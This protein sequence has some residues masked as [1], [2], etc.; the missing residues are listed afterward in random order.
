ME[1]PRKEAP[2]L[3]PDD[4]LQF[5]IVD[6]YIPEADRQ[7]EK[8]EE[9]D[10]YTMMIYGATQDG[11]TVCVNITG[12]EPYFYVKPPETWEQYSDYVFA[13]K[14]ANMRTEMEEEYY[15]CTFR[16]DGRESKYNK[17]IIPKGYEDHFKDMSVVKKKEF[18]GFTNNADF[19]YIK[20]T[21]KSL[22]LYNSLKYYFQSLKPKGFIM[23]ES[24]IDPFLR[25][26]HRQNI[27]PCG[28]VSIK[29][30]EINDD[31]DTRCDYNIETSHE[32]IIPIEVNNIAPLLIASFD[33]ECTSSHGDFPVAKKDYRKVAQDLA[34]IAKA[35]YDIT[36][37][38][39]LYWLETMY[40]TDAI[41]DDDLKVHR[42]YAKHKVNF[43]NYKERVS[44]ISDEIIEILNK[45]A[46]IADDSDDEDED[47]KKAIKPITLKEQNVLEGK[48]NALLSDILP[49]L[50]GDKIIQ[51][52]T[53]VHRYGSDE[54][55]YKNIITLNSCASIE[56]TD[57]I[58]CQSEKDVLMQWKNLMIS[59]NPD[60][61]TGYNIF[62]F[63][64]EYIWI[65]AQ[66]NSIID[67]FSRGLGRKITRK[68]TLV[69]QELSSSALG[70][71]ILKY[72]DMDGTVVID[73]FKVMQREHKLDS[74]K[75]D[76]VAHIFI[77]DKKD[78][79]K[80]HEIFQKFLGTAEDRC[81]IAKYCVQDCALVNRL[82]HKLKILE[83]NIGMGNVC[84][85]PLNY[86]FKRGQGIKIFSLIAKQCM[87]KGH[88]IPVIRAF[89]AKTE[90]DVDGYEGAVVLEP[91]EGI[92][93]NDP[94][95]V[96][97]YGSLYPSSMIAR[98]LSHDCYVMDPKY[99]VDDP[100]IDYIKVSYDLYEGTGDKK[101]KSGVKE[102][103]FA[104]YKDGRKGIIADILTMLLQ[105]RKNTR[106]KM[107]YQTI[108]TLDNLKY[109][110]VLS[111]K[112]DAYELLDIDTN[113]KVVILKENVKE[114]K[115][116]FN[117]FEQDVFDALQ[118]AYKITANSLYG[119]IGARTSPIYL[120]DIAACT[121]ATG[122]EMIML[123]KNFVE[124]NYQ[125]EVIYGDS[126]MPY[127]PLT[128]KTAHQI[129]VATFETIE[130]Q[131]IPYNEF[132][133]DEVGRYNKEQFLPNDIQVWTHKGWAKVKRII[134]HK[135][136]K[137]IYRVQTSLG[138]VD[139]T[140]DHSL[141]DSNADIIKPS[142][143]VV[144]QELL[145]S[146]PKI[147][148]YNQVSDAQQ[149]YVYGQFVAN[150]FYHKQDT[151]Y[152]VMYTWEIVNNSFEV[153]NKCKTYL[154]SIEKIEFVIIY[155]NRQYVLMPVAGKHL[156]EFVAKYACCYY[157]YEHDS[158]RDKIVPHRI[159]NGTLEVMIAFKKG[160]DD[161][162]HTPKNHIFDA[163]QQITAQSY[164]I[165]L[166][167][168]RYHFKI[169]CKENNIIITMT[170][171]DYECDDKIQNI[172]VLHEQYHGYVYD[173]ETEAGVFHGGVGN[174]ILKNTDSIFCRFP[175]KDA[176]G[177][178]V[179]GKDSLQ[180]AIEVG[181][182][183]E[184]NIVS[185]MPRPQKLNYEKSLYPFILFSKKRYVGNLYETDVNKF[186]Q[187]SMGIVLKRR[188]NAPIVKKIYGGIIDILLNQQDLH[189]SIKFLKD[190]LHD[191]VNGKTPI[192]DLV[193]SKSLRASY[194][195]ASKIPHKVLADRIGERDPGNKPQV[196]DRVP[197]V[198]IKVP[199]A[200]LQG[201]RIESPDYIIENNLTPDYLHYITNQ[202]MNPVLQLYAL[203]L[204][205]LP[206]YNKSHEY[207]TEVEEEL[208][209][210]PIYQDDA[211]RKNR[212][213]N[214][215]LNM[216]KELLFDEYIYM[217]SEPKV[218]RGTKKDTVSNEVR[219]KKQKDVAAPVIEGILMAEIKVVQKKETKVIESVAKIS[220]GKDIIW[221]Q[222]NDK[223]K[224]KSKEII[225]II[226]EMVDVAK[227]NSAKLSI[228]INYKQFASD[229]NK[230]LMCY[231]ELEK[232]TMVDDNVIETAM[233]Q[234]DLGTMNN[235]R[236]IIPYEAI[237]GLRN[238]FE[239]R[240]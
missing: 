83:N 208:K 135:T 227:Q 207:W 85:V 110:G 153:L 161:S 74:Y 132:K 94:I 234:N 130:A 224:D 107:E 5:Q 101:R 195:D 18:W 118:L 99:Q 76:N 46:D 179:Y 201:D 136:L 15:K 205:E 84:L 141:L 91:K 170:H 29:E 175:L 225:A 86:L 143:C 41:I 98:N 197:F 193:I 33:I 198:Y 183:V 229:Y 230:S 157:E 32:N 176:N 92:Y 188:D 77:G 104:Q 81:I 152:G 126:V 206:N 173:I 71:N 127:T 31:I 148:Y 146:K 129:Y 64:M 59:L 22:A 121:T 43:S 217:L 116:T 194:K 218:K 156:H 65:R 164:I 184:K 166:Q 186:K 3:N 4:E 1:I 38:F 213:D 108:I 47:E 181:K 123:A 58:A 24:N 66:E 6:W 133:A 144:G 151:E 226:L 28:W 89:D 199:D 55:I 219:T 214:L 82:L 240:I 150:G 62:G 180:Y 56:N 14:V 27:K 9:P 177:N 163:L 165:L 25:Y 212:M 120:K 233:Q 235:V 44:Q 216:V 154:E 40:T 54:I 106:K 237:I 149:A 204:D 221:Q 117:K 61:L 8:S 16:K 37:E 39:I 239:I 220:R 128:Y 69:R 113:A 90:M 124:K 138:I 172:S 147:D 222:K 7:R 17:K 80:P 105:E 159:L 70:E 232:A 51:I 202:I 114:M 196:N 168:L 10:L 160:L 88:L 26:I 131:W 238:Y 96:F 87:D 60:V 42:V 171:S 100:N 231:K 140:E 78:D 75:L 50:K 73:L 19:R 52:G 11:H 109:S 185:I 97:D 115:D 48:L 155:C 203:C 79:L 72:F 182:H 134:R 210:K 57:V 36:E 111:E 102:C 20:I 30:Y 192:T 53:T 13:A 223:G 211:K 125:A 190:E 178:K 209:K 21:V 228:K 167:Q 189:E 122:R 145:H 67:E 174:M 169:N 158:T 68:C 200:K 142:E 137:K 63:D 162:F 93:L 2:A 35:G 187:K 191:L 49:P 103:V 215:K 236:Q 112:Q 12:Y 34:N 139:V 45:I 119:Q 95:V 23:Y